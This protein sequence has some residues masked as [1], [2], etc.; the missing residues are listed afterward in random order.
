M[1]IH[2]VLL[3]KSVLNYQLYAKYVM[4]KM[5]LYL[6]IMLRV[7]FFFLLFFRLITVCTFVTNLPTMT[8][9]IP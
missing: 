5:H 2:S 3:W 4:H 6:H 9:S 1:T 8:T 7:E